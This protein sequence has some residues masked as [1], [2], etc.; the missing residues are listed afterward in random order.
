MPFGEDIDV[1]DT[2]QRS[3]G[4]NYA[5]DEI[6][7]KF[8][9]YERDNETDLDF[10]Q[11]RYYN[12]DHGR[13]TTV[14][15]VLMMADRQI[16]PQQVNLYA[17]CRNNP[18]AFVDPSG[19]ILDPTT[20]K[21]DARK[22]YEK[23]VDFL[24][25]DAK[26]YASELATLEQLK[27]SDVNYVVR[28]DQS[29]SNFGSGTEGGVTTDGK[30]VFINLANQGNSK[31][32]ISLNA[33]FGHELEHARQFD[34]GEFGF[35]SD[36]NGNFVDKKG[37]FVGG[38]EAVDI[39]D[40]VKAWS[41][42]AK[43]A[44]STDFMVKGGHNDPEFQFPILDEFNKSTNKGGILAKIS[45]NYNGMNTRE[46]NVPRVN[47]KPIGTLVRPTLV[48]RSSGDKLKGFWVNR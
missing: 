40:E 47:G 35:R 22:A 18:L 20:W 45:D 3:A 14:D 17:Y 24:N 42:T 2:S 1:D 6:K 26:K 4:L 19:M 25:K 41:V 5:S 39:T 32:Q 31:E 16:D 46:T 28:L 23:Y 30:D 33:T 27:K 34:S 10:A 8:T 21:K 38:F 43:L 9:T 48:D 7:Q 36:K 29:G 44:T 15:P 12:K 11:A 13:F 37:N